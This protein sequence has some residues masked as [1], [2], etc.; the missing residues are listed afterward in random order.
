MSD[1]AFE[2]IAAERRARQAAAQGQAAEQ[3]TTTSKKLTQP[4]AG[5]KQ[6]KPRWLMIALFILSALYLLPEA[7]FNAKLVE[8]AGGGG[9]DSH[10][11]HLVELFG[12]TIS[13]IGVSLLLADWLLKGALVRSVP[14]VIF[15]FV[16]IFALAW[17]TVFFGQKLL[18]DKL[19]V[20]PSSAEQRQEAF[21]AS[22]LR[23]GLATNAVNISGLPYNPEHAAK[24]EE[25]T[26]LALMGGLV[27]ANSEFLDHVETQ[28]HAIVERYI[29]NR[30]GLDFDNYY[31]RYKGMR[32]RLGDG[33]EQ[34]QDGVKRY[35]SA[36]ASSPSRADKAWEQ[37]E[38]EV[39]SGWDKYQK[40]HQAYWGRAEVRAQEMAPEIADMFDDRNW[41]IDRYQKKNR[42]PERLNSCT[43]NVEKKHER[44]LEKYHLT[45]QPLDYWLIREEGRIKGE[46]TVGQ[47]VM[48]LGLSALV[49]G[50]EHLSGDAGEQVVNWV[51][52]RNV[53]DYT[54]K[55]MVLWQEKFQ[56]ETGYPMGISEL[57]AFRQH[58]VTARKVRARLAKEGIQL[59]SSWQINQIGVFQ[60]AVAKRVKQEADNKWRQEMKRQGWSLKPNM[61]WAQ[62]QR[63]DDIQARIKREMGE[64]YYVSPMLADW[65]NKEFYRFAIVPNIK[66]ETEHWIG[67]LDA[68]LSQ[69]ADGGPLAEE[70]KN[71]LRSVLVPPISMGLSLLLVILTALKLPLK[72]WQLVRPGQAPNPLR[73]AGISL[74]LIAAVLIVPVT[75]M[76]S[77]F[78]AG[79]STAGYFFDQ[80]EQQ[81]SPVAAMA[82]RWVVHT[83][84]VVQPLG[85]GLDQQLGVTR[86]FKQNLEG[87]IGQLDAWVMPMLATEAAARTQVSEVVDEKGMLRLIPLTVKVNADNATIRIMNIKPRFEQ[88]MALPV[89]NYDIQVSAPGYKTVRRWVKH[90]QAHQQHSFTLQPE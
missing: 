12:R 49:A 32:E 5:K 86:W 21:F 15:G 29:T 30:A 85:V 76:G 1:S 81:S 59:A 62:F 88:G 24:P 72:F 53:A 55:I 26:F 11:L 10:D 47:T 33:W 73:D 74:G 45:Y 87:H 75:M 31:T 7:I 17:P 41:C 42:D 80:V 23:S 16:V 70:G 46:T 50:L 51:Y 38:S 65:N 4:K 79:E 63:S 64:R 44:L 20:D 9:M 28:K 25:M 84:P 18:I 39:A 52:S 27:Y 60:Q 77:K 22:V 69:F 68:S 2:Q 61:S 56:K 34:Y 37:V 14:R 78:T 3:T 40:A 57:Q 19:L 82:L 35:N 90:S 13:G 89:S 36:I 58:E 54:P 67:Y 43:R 48:T 6:D 66:R 71:A 8:V 83:Q